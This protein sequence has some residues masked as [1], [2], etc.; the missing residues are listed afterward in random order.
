LLLRNNPI[1]KVSYPIPLVI[2]L[3]RI[4]IN[5]SLAPLRII[6]TVNV[7]FTLC[8]FNDLSEQQKSNIFFVAAYFLAIFI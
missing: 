6:F 5:Q 8:Y 2:D 1:N 7:L 4:L 3:S